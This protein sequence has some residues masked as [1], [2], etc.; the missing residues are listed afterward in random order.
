MDRIDRWIY[1]VFLGICFISILFQS[2]IPL[3][4][5]FGGLLI[6]AIVYGV[7]YGFAA[8]S[9]DLEKV[10]PGHFLIRFKK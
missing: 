10:E 1:G 8:Y 7:I 3:A 6:A 9:K 4:I 2:V 5:A